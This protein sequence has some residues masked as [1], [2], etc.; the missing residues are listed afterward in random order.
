MSRA[1]VVLS[2][3]NASD[4]SKAVAAARPSA[5]GMDHLLPYELKVVCLW[6]PEINLHIADM[7]DLIES[8]GRWPQALTKGAVSFWTKSSESCPSADNFRPMTI[9]SCS[10]LQTVGENQARPAL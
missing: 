7:Y 5:A 4:V 2:D 9:L 1:D 3:I 10:A 8:T 6:R